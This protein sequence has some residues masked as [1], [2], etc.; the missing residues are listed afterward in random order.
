MVRTRFSFVFTVVFFITVF[1]VRILACACCAE[2]G[3]YSI[4]TLKPDSYHLDL[5]DEFRFAPRATLYMT[6]A[7][8]DAI[9]GLDQVRLEDEAMTASI[10]EGF[11]LATSFAGRR[12]W[13]FSFKT[14]KG[15]AGSLSFLLPNQMV[16]YAVDIHDDE[17]DGL[18]PLLYKEFRFKGAVG[19]ASGFTRAGIVRGTTFFLVFQ[20]R[21]RGCNELTDFKN[22][23]LEI[24]GPRASYAFFGKLRSSE[25]KPAD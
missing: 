17:E 2:P 10:I 9:R 4:R 12:T 24:D 18:G 15:N 3:T 22:W 5:I 23:R 7:G 19:S 8:F 11:D 1:S 6:E 14:P 16:S 20:G 25:M 21:G 13:K